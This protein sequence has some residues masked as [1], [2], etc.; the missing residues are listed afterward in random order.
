M[1][2]GGRN[3]QML[4]AESFPQIGS[5][6]SEYQFSNIASIF[7][8]DPEILLLKLGCHTQSILSGRSWDWC[9]GWHSKKQE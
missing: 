2:T 5:S 3:V 4:R 9:G 6:A 1:V 7:K 8:T